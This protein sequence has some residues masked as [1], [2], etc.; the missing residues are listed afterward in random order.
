LQEAVDQLY[1][2]KPVAEVKKLGNKPPAR[3]DLSNVKFTD[4]TCP[5]TNEN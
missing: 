4:K 1:G 5:K 2:N 3:I